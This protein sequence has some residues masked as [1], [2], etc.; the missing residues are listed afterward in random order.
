MFQDLP[1]FKPVAEAQHTTCV[2]VPGV[3]SFDEIKA[4]ETSI[5][6]ARL[7]GECFGEENLM[8]EASILSLFCRRRH[9][10]GWRKL[11]LH[12]NGWFHRSL[13]GLKQKL[14]AVACKVDAEQGW[15]LLSVPEA[16]LVSDEVVKG[17]GHIVAQAVS[18][19]LSSDEADDEVQ[20]LLPSSREVAELATLEAVKL[21]PCADATGGDEVRRC[22]ALWCNVRV[23]EYHVH[24]APSPALPDIHHH[25]TDSLV[26]IDVMLSDPT[27]DFNGGEF[28]TL[29]PGGELKMDYGFCRG[30]A[31]IFVSHK[32]H[33]VQPVRKGERRVLVLELWRGPECGCPHRCEAEWPER[34]CRQAPK[35]RLG[36][37]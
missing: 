35:E 24:I 5:H 36:E 22:K 37:V 19:D 13:P 28:G 25:D 23:A 27:N 29:Q 12:T 6:A 18:A 7:H 17:D 3:L 33:C 30:D 11:F 14:M 9:R 34:R 31:L 21:E 32:Y 16:A 1:R 2:R 15:G 20:T 8:S 10:G 4:L 26:T